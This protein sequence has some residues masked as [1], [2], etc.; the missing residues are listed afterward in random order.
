MRQFLPLPL[1]LLVNFSAIGQVDCRSA[2][3][4]QDLISRNPGLSSQVQAIENFTRSKLQ[5]NRTMLTGADNNGQP[6]TVITIPVIVHILYNSASQNISDAQVQSQIQVL[7][8]DYRKLNS[9]TTGIPGYFSP[10]AAD[11]GF[12]VRAG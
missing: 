5:V 1:L 4:K 3:Y 12:P 11:C 2:Q 9:D 10:M 6:V 8:R 7:N